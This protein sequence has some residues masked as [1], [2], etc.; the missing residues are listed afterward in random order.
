MELDKL[1]A[2]ELRHNGPIPK[3]LLTLVDQ[4]RELEGIL[5]CP[6]LPEDQRAMIEDELNDLRR[7]RVQKEI[8]NSLGIAAE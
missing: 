6:A 1:N 3:H 7:E 5:K 4:I 2:L 8:T